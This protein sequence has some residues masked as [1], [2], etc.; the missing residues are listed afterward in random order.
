VPTYPEICAHSLEDLDILDTRENMPYHNTAEDKQLYESTILPFWQGKTIR[1]K[2]F[3]RMPEEWLQCYEAGIWTEF[4][5]QRA[6][7][8]TAGGERIFQKGILD[9][10]EE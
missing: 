9:I 2:L 8:H 6:P 3:Q 4:M 10:K 7:G 5:E 1:E